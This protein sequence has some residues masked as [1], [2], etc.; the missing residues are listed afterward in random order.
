V[1]V[2]L[3]FEFPKENEFDTFGVPVDEFCPK[4]KEFCPVDVVEL[5]FC[6]N[7]NP[8]FNGDN[9][10]V[11]GEFCPKLNPE[12]LKTLGLL[13]VDGEFCPKNPVLFKILELELEGLVVAV[14]FC[15]KLNP[16][17]VVFGAGFNEFCPKLNPVFEIL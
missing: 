6:P 3:L 11:A 9:E 16:V 15:P 14:E 13:D 7:E 12:L 2:V 8:E 4:P 10:V 5:G 1:P 17:L